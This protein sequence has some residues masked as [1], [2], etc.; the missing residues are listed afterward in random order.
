[1][2]K[3]EA[4]ESLNAGNKLTHRHFNKDEWVKKISRH[5]YQYEDGYDTRI[6]YFWVLREEA[7]MLDGWSIFKEQL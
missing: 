4:I 2:N 6:S 7:N 3:E 1:M 5:Y